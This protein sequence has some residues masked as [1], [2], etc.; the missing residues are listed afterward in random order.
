MHYGNVEFLFQAA[1]YFK[2]FGCFD[3]F[4]VDTPESRGDGFDG[5]DKFVG[6]FF[7]YFDIEYI[8]SCIDFEKQTFTFHYRFAAKSA[9][10]TQSQNSC[11]V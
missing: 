5:F 8:D 4:Q 7:I 6:V 10:I 9:D 3:I 2:T 1:F 11:T